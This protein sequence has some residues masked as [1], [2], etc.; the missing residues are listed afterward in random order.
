[1]TTTWRDGDAESDAILARAVETPRLLVA[2]DFDGT[3]S[4]LH[5]RPMESRAIPAAKEALAAL[6]RV[7]DT[8]VGLVSGRS[9]GDLRV[10]AEHGDESSIY[11]AGS[12][13]AEFWVPGEG[14]VARGDSAD[15]E[16]LRD[17][18]RESAEALVAD[19]EGAWIEPKSFG[20]A[21]HTRLSSEED[22]ERAQRA[23]D[24]LVAERAP[25]WR[26]RV[27]YNLAEYSFTHEGKD[28]GVAA[29]RERVGAT[30]VLFAG[31]DVTDEDALRSLGAD[32]VGVR[33]GDGESAAVLRVEDPEHMAALLYAVAVRRAAA[34]Q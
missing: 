6:S 8:V 22:G 24:E 20:L 30:A 33:V 5:D 15:D 14:E 25:H 3:L 7:D 10:I 19:I 11:L 2:L 18:L 1:M 28:A 32:D 31:D 27:G 13:G 29:L 12:H 23:V 26:R 17:A 34:R 4:H 16:A 9:L 21:V